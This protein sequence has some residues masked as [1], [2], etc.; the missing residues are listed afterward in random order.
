MWLRKHE[1]IVDIEPGLCAN[2]AWKSVDW[3]DKKAYFRVKLDAR[4]VDPQ[5]DAS[6][7]TI[8]DYKT[9]KQYPEHTQLME[10]YGVMQFLEAP[11]ISEVVTELWYVDQG[12]RTT[13]VYDRKAALARLPNLKKRVAAVL[14]DRKFQPMGVVNGKCAWCPHSKKRGGVCDAG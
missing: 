12:R 9:G 2:P 8:I 6:S 4:Y 3:F 14:N 11:K 10:D 13:A 7:V 5:S 1:N